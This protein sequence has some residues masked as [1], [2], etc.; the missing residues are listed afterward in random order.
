MSD[1]DEPIQTVI[2][3][4]DRSGFPFQTAITHLIRRSKGWS[5]LSTEYPWRDS[6]GSENFLD[7][8]ATNGKFILPIECKKTKEVQTF[9]IPQGA[10]A[11][12]IRSRD[13]ADFRCLRT[14]YFP[15]QNGMP[16]P[17]RVD[18]ATWKIWPVSPTSE[19][20][21]VSTSTSGK[22]QR[23][24]ERDASLL[25][26]AT[27][28]LAQQHF[29]LEKGASRLLLPLIVTNSKLFTARYHPSDVSLETGEFTESPKDE[30]EK[31]PWV[32]FSKSF[33]AL[34]P[35]N[36]SIFIVNATFLEEFLQNLEL[37]PDEKRTL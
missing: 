5:V 28:A 11:G 31:A 12:L 2:Q 7:I 36:R 19:F 34:D 6:D 3:S 30:V 35:E 14:T 29:K 10:L 20:C 16:V 25:V 21:I 32:R 23:L 18:R 37:S 13:V 4:L 26:R 9:L 15:A 33:T 24:L 22:D 1:P 17:N 8:I 27:D